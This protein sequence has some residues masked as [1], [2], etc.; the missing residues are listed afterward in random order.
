MSIG[1]GCKGLDLSQEAMDKRFAGDV[2]A[3]DPDSL[4]IS[5]DGTWDEVEGELVFTEDG[6]VA[7][8]RAWYDQ[9]KWEKPFCCQWASDEAEKFDDAPE[10][11]NSGKT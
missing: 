10:I 9:N 2:K 8:C 4:K 7:A 11:Y 5:T 1:Y 6:M 3:N